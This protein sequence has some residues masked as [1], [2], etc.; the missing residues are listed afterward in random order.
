MSAFRL[1]SRPLQ[2]S[3]RHLSTSLPSRLAAVTQKT[4]PE[5]LSAAALHA[6][7][8]MRNDW[9]RDEIQSIYDSPL[10]DLLYHGAKV[11]RENF[12]PRE[13]QQCTLLSIKT[14]GCTEDCK[15]CPQSS[16]YKTSVKAQ[17][18]LDSEEILF[19]AQRAKDAGS[20]R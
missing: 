8:P 16:R 13:V 4:T 10:M 1:I 3:R 11:H 20:T 19:A 9:T 5:A 18:I 17:K 12:N 7:G 6:S 14:G 15:Y 2:N